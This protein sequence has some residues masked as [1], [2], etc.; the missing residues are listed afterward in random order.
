MPRRPVV[1]VMGS[2]STPEIELAEPLARLL[3]QRGVSLLTG[4][5]AG[6]MESV[7]AAFAAVPGRTGTIIAVVPGIPQAQAESWDAR[8]GLDLPPVAGHATER[9]SSDV[10]NEVRARGGFKPG[11]TVAPPGY[12]NEWAE[13]VIQ[14]HLATSGT[15]GTDLTSRNHINIL[16]SDV[17]VALP[18]GPGTLSEVQLANI[19]GKQA[20]AFLGPEED[21]KTIASLATAADL[22]VPIARTI[23][24]VD[25]FLQEHLMGRLQTLSTGLDW[26][27]RLEDER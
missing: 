15:A 22:E 27:P 4:G 9:G 23:D 7:C 19:Y 3:A 25:A 5:G 21:E 18:G 17:V 14:T 8:E 6:T 1:G 24:E 10:V 20:I 12:P 2:G 11:P 13:V 16:S 26:A